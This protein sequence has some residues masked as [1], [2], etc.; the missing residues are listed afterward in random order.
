M[1]NL[2]ELDRY[3]TKHDFWPQTIRSGAFK[4]YVN[5]RSFFVIASVDDCKEDGLW[6]H[7]SVTPSNQKRCPTWNEMCAIKDMFFLP[8][9]ECIEFHPKHSQYVNHHEYC[10]HIW[11]P[12]DGRLKEPKATE[13]ETL[14]SR[15][16]RLEQM[17]SELSDVPLNPDTEEIEEQFKSFPAGTNREEI[18]H[19]FDERH[20]KGVAYLLYG[21]EIDRAPE[22]AQFMYLKQ[23]CF[24][25]ESTSCQYNRK[26]E[27]RFAMVHERKPRINDYDGCIDYDFSQGGD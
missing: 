8:E 6:E 17:W 1:R 3:R 16:E 7:V 19:W 14:A 9:E 24:E 27:C 18:W 26:G 10:L 25:C 22:L 2:N 13:M 20:S 21:D 12:T 23:L 5:G 4:V 11:R 15:D